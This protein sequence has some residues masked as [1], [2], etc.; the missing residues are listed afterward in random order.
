MTADGLP[1]GFHEAAAEV[2]RRSSSGPAAA[3]PDSVPH[4]AGVPR[5]GPD[6][7]ALT[8]P[9]DALLGAVLAAMLGGED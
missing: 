8:G 4:R 5:A 2:F 9:D 3:G 7:A 1:G 6:G